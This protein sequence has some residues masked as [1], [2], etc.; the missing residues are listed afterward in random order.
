MTAVANT[1]AWPDLSSAPPGPT[2]ETLQVWAQIV[3]KVRLA[4][5]PWLNH[6]WHATFHISARG[7]ATPLIPHERVSFA[8]EFDLIASQ[9]IVRVS[10]GG[11]RRIALAS[12]SPATF[13]SGLMDAL[14]ALGV[15]TDIVPIPNEM[16]EATPFPDDTRRREYD[17]DAAREYWQALVQVDRISAPV[18]V[19]VFGQ[20][21]SGA[22]L[23][24]WFRYG[25]DALFRPAGAAASGRHSASAGRRDP[26]SLLS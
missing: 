4:R 24:G 14:A 26:G 11:E 23:L 5:T 25:R 7:L 6:S 8:M 10:D 19:K 15:A 21:Q 17:A 3:G 16:A 2:I 12:E 13:Y 22:S 9:L 20:M 18:Q 1:G